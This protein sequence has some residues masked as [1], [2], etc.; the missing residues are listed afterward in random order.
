MTSISRGASPAARKATRQRRHA[1]IE[2]KEGTPAR[3]RAGTSDGGRR[4]RLRT[5]PRQRR[6]TGPE[7]GGGNRAIDAPGRKIRDDGKAGRVEGRQAIL[8]AARRGANR[9]GVAA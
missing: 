8:G 3:T 1:A 4:A 5:Q 2:L 6:G 7:Y 9:G